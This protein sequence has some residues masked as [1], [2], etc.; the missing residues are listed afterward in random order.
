MLLGWLIFRESSNLQKSVKICASLGTPKHQGFLTW[1]THKNIGKCRKNIKTF[2]QF[3]AGKHHGKH[4]HT[5]TDRHR[6]THTH[7]GCCCD[8]HTDTHTQTHTHRDTQ[9]H[10]ETHRDTHT[11]TDTHRHTHRHTHTHTGTHTHTKAHTHTHTPRRTHTKARARTHTHTHTHTH[12]G[13]PGKEG[14]GWD[15][16]CPLK[17]VPLNTVWK[18]WR[19]RP[20]AVQLGVSAR[21][22]ASA[23][24]CIQQTRIYP[25]PMVWPLPRPWS[26]TM[27]PIPLWAL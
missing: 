2:S 12:Q 26:E 23:N 10:T 7:T 1:Q 14:Q 25:Y 24:N 11:H 5:H 16:V 6:H 17:F 21:V 20:I 4:T 27:V 22:P 8:R 9:R 18:A 13:K 19:Q 15:L 3:P